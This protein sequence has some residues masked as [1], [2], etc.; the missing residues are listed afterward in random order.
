[1]PFSLEFR[2]LQFLKKLLLF[3]NSNQIPN[4]R[5]MCIFMNNVFF[6]KIIP[7]IVIVYVIES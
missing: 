2:S 4:L 1:M 5:Y 7:S 3:Q 6:L